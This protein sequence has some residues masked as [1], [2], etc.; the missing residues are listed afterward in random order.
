MS[1]K[2]TKLDD[3]Q[4]IPAGNKK[5]RNKEKEKVKWISTE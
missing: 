3:E 2:S 5:Q 4:K 1:R